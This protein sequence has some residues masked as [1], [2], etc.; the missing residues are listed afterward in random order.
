MAVLAVSYLSVSTAPFG[1]LLQTGELLQPEFQASTSWPSSCNT[2]NLSFAVPTAAVRIQMRPKRGIQV[3]KNTKIIS[4]RG[5]R[6][7]IGVNKPQGKD[8]RIIKNRNVGFGI[9]RNRNRGPT[10]W[11]LRRQ[12]E[13]QKKEEEKKRKKKEDEK[14]KKEDEK[15]KKKRKEQEEHR[16]RQTEE[17]R[18]QANERTFRSFPPPPRPTGAVVDTEKEVPSPKH[19]GQAAQSEERTK[20]PNN[21]RNAKHPKP[22][23][24]KAHVNEVDVNASS[25]TFGPGASGLGEAGDASAQ[26]GTE[27]WCIW[28]WIVI[29]VI[30]L[31]AL[32]AVLIWCSCGG[33][34]KAG[35][36]N[37]QKNAQNLKNAW[38]ARSPE[39]AYLL[40]KGRLP[41]GK[42]IFSRAESLV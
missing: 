1:A 32:G 42:R 7:P 34:E 19:A 20:C 29:G 13:I 14:R 5:N 2:K 23:A 11:H 27:T 33:G 25:K 36:K 9:G 4:I 39:Q 26:S 38:K 10:A 35:R 3:G 8:T 31:A 12:R 28:L 18:R 16:R 17:R 37:T 21:S 30:L 22:D 41:Q 15:R 40:P 24:N 6:G